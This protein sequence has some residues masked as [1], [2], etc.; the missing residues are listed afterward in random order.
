MRPPPSED[1]AEAAVNE[2][3]VDS[4]LAYPPTTWNIKLDCGSPIATE[5]YVQPPSKYTCNGK[6]GTP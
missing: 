2:R 5:S 4:D 1:N 3:D 6:V